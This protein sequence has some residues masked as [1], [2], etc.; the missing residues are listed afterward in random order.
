[1]FCLYAEAD[2]LRYL[3]IDGLLAAVQEGVD[4]T[5]PYGHCTACLNGQYPVTPEW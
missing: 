2:S 5:K 3:S 1:M 4:K